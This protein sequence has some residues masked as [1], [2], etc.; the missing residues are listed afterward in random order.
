MATVVFWDS[1]ENRPRGRNSG[2]LDGARQPS[3]QAQVAEA[4]ALAKQV[5][6]GLGYVGVPTLE[7]FAT[8][9]GPVFNEMAPRVHNSGHWTSKAQSPASLKTTSARSAACRWAIPGWPQRGSRCAT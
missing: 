8:E 3:V 6:D 2:A 7:F 4:R 9:Q 1:A 5:A